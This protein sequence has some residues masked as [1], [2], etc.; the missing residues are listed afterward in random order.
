MR[1]FNNLFITLASALLLNACRNDR[2]EADISGINIPKV[3]FQRLDKDLFAITEQ[4]QKQKEIELENAYGSFYKQFIYTIINANKSDTNYILQFVKDKD[5][6]NAYQEVLKTVS[7]KDINELED[8]LTDCEKRFRYF[9][10]QR[11]LPAKHIAYFSGFNYNIVYPDST[12]GISLEMYLGKD[13]P[14]YKMLQ[15]P[16]YQVR[17]LSKE[18]MLPNLVR[19]WLITEFDNAEPTNNLLSHMIFYGKIFYAC[20]ALMPD[21][22][23]SV[24]IAYSKQQLD[25]CNKYE[26]NLWGFF[27]QENR[28]YENNLKTVTEFT[29]EGPFT[30]S[31][32]KECPPRIAMWVGWQIVKSYMEHNE[33][34]TLEALM[35]D[36][37]AQKI[38]NKSK[39]RP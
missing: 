17:S 9:F 36:S 34:V 5:M 21:I 19:G 16:Y 35:K 3:K 22:Q 37:D 4:N 26:K 20:D 25:Y 38:L 29:T 15:W 30:G 6:N 1:L 32:S 14:Y 7:E 33:S 18:Y 31:I 39:Y 23:D 8:N 11:K 13:S 27:A 2:I 12:L 10:P 24:K 28:L